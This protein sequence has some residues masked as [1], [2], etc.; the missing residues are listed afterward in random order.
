MVNYAVR[1]KM[2][3]GTEFQIGGEIHVLDRLIGQGGMS[4]VYTAYRK[5]NGGTEKQYIAV[6]QMTRE[7][8]KHLKKNSTL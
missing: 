3:K 7:N 8:L 2:E 1:V 4:Q 5:S 6:W